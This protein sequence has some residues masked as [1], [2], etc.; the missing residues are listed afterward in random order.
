MIHK[1]PEYIS[2]L[3]EGGFEI[4]SFDEKSQPWHAYTSE[5]Q[6][7]FLNVYDEKV[8]MHGEDNG[9]RQMKEFFNAVTKYFENGGQGARIVAKKLN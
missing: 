9:P 1:N 4:Q 5:R 7:M 3:K 6:K 8:K 2:A